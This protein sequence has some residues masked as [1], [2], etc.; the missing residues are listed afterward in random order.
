MRIVFIGCVKFSLDTLKKLVDLNATVVGV[1]SKESSDFN[2]D[3]SDLRPLCNSHSIPFKYCDD[4]NSKDSVN[5]IS[6]LKPDIIFCFGWSSLLKEDL[7]HISPLGVIGYHPS[8][9]PK[10][11]GRHPLIWA[12][13]L[14]LEKSASTFFFMNDEA[15]SGDI[16]SQVEFDISSKDNA[17]S[18]YYKVTKIA[19]GQ[20][21][22]FIPLLEHGGNSR[23]KQDELQSSYWRKRNE[24]DG[25]I[26]FR[27]SSR[28]IYNLTRGLSKPYIGAHIKYRGKKIKIWKVKAIINSN[29]N[30]EPGKI[31]KVYK[32]T[33]IVK[34]SDGAIEIID[35]DF[36]K[37]PKAGEY[38]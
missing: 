27:M 9:L 19:L 17:H 20:I 36:K 30:I 13:V 3:Y 32:K 5:W 10:N 22:S 7:L 38:L 26:D 12:I 15:D 28:N 23:I 29:E 33:I 1:C 6:G 34:S 16:L 2:S 35:H 14:G 4:I 31:I 8:K 18:I 37:L 21:E 25:L 24:I 11:R